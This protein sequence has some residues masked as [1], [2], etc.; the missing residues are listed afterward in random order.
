MPV[1]FLIKIDDFKDALKKLFASTPKGKQAETEYFDFSAE[2]G[3]VTLEAQGFSYVS[4]TEVMNPGGAQVPYG[5]VHRLR[6]L[7]ATFHE[8]SITVS[9]TDGEFKV[10][11]TGFTN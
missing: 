8:K 7:L 10:G 1:D 3:E 5:V 4:P 11:T 6:Q 2:D 9:I